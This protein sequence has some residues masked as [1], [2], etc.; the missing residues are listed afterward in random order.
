LRDPDGAP[1]FAPIIQRSR[2]GTLRDGGRVGD[3]RLGAAS[4]VMPETNIN[5]RLEAFC[6]GVFAIALTLLIIDIRIPPSAH[7]GTTRD[8]WLA[9]WHLLPSLFA[10]L[11]SFAI[12]VI[13][14]ANHHAVIR[15][16]D[17]SSHPFIFANGLLLLT[18][19]F[20]PFPT[21]LMGD[22]LLTD[23]SAPAV[24]LYSAVCGFQAVA[25]NLLTRAALRPHAL[26]RNHQATLAMRANHKYSYYAF[27]LYTACAI[28]AFW[29]PRTVAVAITLI[30]IV[31]LIVGI[32]IKSD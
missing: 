16:V 15:L 28:A 29:L 2:I 8:L 31:W 21:A 23:H 30:W 13:T 12:I 7:T 27:G 1:I 20:I 25:W 24:V 9:L 5:S 26:T 18:V 10:F 19:V 22:Y 17:K 32:R 4:G 6:D 14:W 11:L 3:A